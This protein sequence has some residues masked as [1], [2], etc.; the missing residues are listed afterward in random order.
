MVGC[1]RRKIERRE[2]GGLLRCIGERR[3]RDYRFGGSGGEGG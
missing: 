2:V 1:G 3:P